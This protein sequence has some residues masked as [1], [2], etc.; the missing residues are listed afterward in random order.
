MFI[1]DMTELGH[2]QGKCI[3]RHTPLTQLLEECTGLLL[4]CWVPSTLSGYSR[5]LSHSY[6]MMSCLLYFD[7]ALRL[8]AACQDIQHAMCASVSAM[9]ME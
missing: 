1:W 8:Y 6:G 7:N 5:I 3:P 9:L 2:G 4:L